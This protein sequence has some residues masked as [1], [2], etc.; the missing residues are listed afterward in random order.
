MGDK[1]MGRNHLLLGGVIFLHI[2]LIF[3]S[4]CTHGIFL[5]PELEDRMIPISSSSRQ[6]SKLKRFDRK[7]GDKKWEEVA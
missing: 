1:K 4:P 5:S 3:L 6:Q 2:P 7:M